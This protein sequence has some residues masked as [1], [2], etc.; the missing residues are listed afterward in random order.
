MALLLWRV[1]TPCP[2]HLPLRAQGDAAL[3]GSMPLGT[4]VFHSQG[5][6]IL[7]STIRVGVALL[8]TFHQAIVVWP[9]RQDRAM[10]FST[11]AE[12]VLRAIT[13]QGIAAFRFNF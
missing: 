13:D 4:P 10:R 8:G 9:F 11:V 7:P 1:K 2:E 12:V 5:H 6:L 3:R